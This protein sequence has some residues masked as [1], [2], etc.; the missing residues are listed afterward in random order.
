[1]SFEKGYNTSS[2][3]Q[4]ILHLLI[5]KSASKHHHKLNS[6]NGKLEGGL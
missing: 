1:M 2:D 6:R 3:D 4:N 5:F